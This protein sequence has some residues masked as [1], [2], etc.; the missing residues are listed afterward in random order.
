MDNNDPNAHLFDR[1]EEQCTDEELICK[2]LYDKNPVRVDALG[3]LVYE[4]VCTII[5]GM[6]GL[7]A[8]AGRQMLFKMTANSVLDMV[9]DAVTPDI[10]MEISFSF[11]MLLGV[12]LT[13]RRYGANLFKEHE[14]ALADMKPSN[15]ETDELYRLALEEF[16][17]RWWD[18]PQPQLGKRTPNDA[19]KEI[20]SEY[21]L[22]D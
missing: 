12:A 4:E 13:N 18:L 22:S 14:K 10:G 1:E 11:D 3:D 19:I 9:M 5:D 21:G 20:L 17:E 2:Q 8:E 6:E 16:E 7:D 15:F